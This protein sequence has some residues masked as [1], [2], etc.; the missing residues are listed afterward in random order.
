MAEWLKAPDLKPGSPCGGSEVRILPC[1]YFW[2][3]AQWQLRRPV[4]A[5][6]EG[7]SPSSP[8]QGD[9]MN[10]AQ[11]PAFPQDDIHSPAL[12]KRDNII[13]ITNTLYQSD[14]DARRYVGFYFI[15]WPASEAL[16]VDVPV[17]E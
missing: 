17:E 4:K 3:V 15:Q 14:S 13:S 7:S 10:K 1:P 11:Q 6:V 8:A 12:V 5:E 16:F 9:Y 2:R